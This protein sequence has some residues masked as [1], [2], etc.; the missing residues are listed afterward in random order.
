[1]VKVILD[2]PFHAVTLGSHG[3][4]CKGLAVHLAEGFHLAPQLSPAYIYELM[5]Y[6]ISIRVMIL[7]DTY[8]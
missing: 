3:V 5:I 1:M 8:M 6:G 7:K 2:H 4:H